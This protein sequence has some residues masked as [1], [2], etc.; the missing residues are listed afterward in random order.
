MA[1]PVLDEEGAIGECLD[2]LRAQT[3]ADLEILVADGG[4][5]D[6][7]RT[8]VEA[9]ARQDRRI[10]LIQN[11]RRI[12]SAG[13]NGILAA[14]S[15]DV[16]VRLDARSF[17]EADYIE[18]V[19]QLLDQTDAAVVG[20]QMVP[21]PRPGPVAAGIAIA[22]ESAW[23]AGPARFHTGGK[24]GPVETVYLGSFDRAWL[25]R[26]GGWAT[27]VGVNEDFELNHRI[28]RAGG[29]VWFDPRLQVGYE[30]RAT[31]RGLIRQYFRY[32]RSKATVLRRH[33][34]S[35]RTRQLV[36]ATLGP[37]ALIAIL[38]RRRAALMSRLLLTAHVLVVAEGACRADGPSRVRLHAA[39]AALLM[40]WSWTVGLE[41]GLIRP[42]PPALS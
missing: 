33:P 15:G 27:D 34:S 4:S 6:A 17:I 7:T 40:H 29:L 42:M 10:R 30:P 13:L 39:V 1:L 3:H 18:L 37:I 41:I 22:N 20:G 9:H 36:P 8:I 2:R 19:L 24:K 23:G 38:G 5:R 12:Q 28:R 14:A 25:D 26:V 31:Y 21:R 16:I 32:G 35:T 11:P